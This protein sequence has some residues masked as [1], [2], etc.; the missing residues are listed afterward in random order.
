[1]FFGRSLTSLRTTA[2]QSLLA[3][4]FDGGLVCAHDQLCV[5]ERNWDRGPLV[6]SLFTILAHT[7]TLTVLWMPTATSVSVR[8]VSY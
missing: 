5:C 3:E 1:M 4:F 8:M 6:S 2:P 7:L